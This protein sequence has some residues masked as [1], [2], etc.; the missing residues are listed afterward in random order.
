MFPIKIKGVKVCVEMLTLLTLCGIYC[1][2]NVF[3]YGFRIHVL[4]KLQETVLI[5]LNHQMQKLFLTLIAKCRQTYR[6]EDRLTDTN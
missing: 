5:I 6:Q 4:I 1:I 3:Y 2:E